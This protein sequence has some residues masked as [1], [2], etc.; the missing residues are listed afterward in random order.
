MFFA[1][2]FH[3]R[4]FLISLLVSLGVGLLSALLTRNTIAI[5]PSLIKPPF[6]PPPM[7]FGIV[8][9]ILY[10]L[11]G[12]SAYLVWKE[13]HH[14]RAL[15][16]YYLQLIVN[17]FWP[18]IFFNLQAFSLAAIWSAVLWILAVLTS[19]SFYKVSKAAFWLFLP[20]V[21]WLTFA[22]Y[23]SFGIWWLN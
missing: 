4:K 13:P 16:Y 17:F 8:W 11:I 22:T 18:I 21:L 6:A 23:L 15:Y 19:V 5:Y 20:Y 1:K 14:S 12:I 10:V 7:V 9:P 2:T 3:L